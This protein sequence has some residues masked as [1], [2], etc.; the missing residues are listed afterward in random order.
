MKKA[1]QVGSVLGINE[2][3]KNLRQSNN[4]LHLSAG[5]KINKILLKYIALAVN[6]IYYSG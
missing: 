2:L 6:V 4:N 1:W 3:K 5:C